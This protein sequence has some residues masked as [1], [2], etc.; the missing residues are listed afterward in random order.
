MTFFTVS[1]FFASS[2][3]GILT[4][5]TL[6]DANMTAKANLA[7]DI[8]E[9]VVQKYLGVT[10]TAL[11]VPLAVKTAVLKYSHILYE[12]RAGLKK[13][14]TGVIT[15]VNDTPDF[16]VYLKE[17]VQEYVVKKPSQYAGI[18]VG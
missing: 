13:S 9:I 15:E 12:Q 11:T 18:S 5:T 3:F 7:V 17:L 10:Y 8:A 1:E 14:G 4:G 6:S 16:P 2:D